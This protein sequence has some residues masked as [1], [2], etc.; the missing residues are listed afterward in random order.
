MTLEFLRDHGKAGASSFPVSAPAFLTGYV[1][2]C[3]TPSPGE[4]L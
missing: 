2:V 3:D 1:P 4:T